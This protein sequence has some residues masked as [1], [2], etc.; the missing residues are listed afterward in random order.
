[1]ERFDKAEGILSLFGFAGILLFLFL[2]TITNVFHFTYG[3]DA[4]VASN[5][6][7]GELIWESGQILPDSWYVSTETQILCTPNLEALF[8]GMTRNLALSMGLACSVMTLLVLAAVLY[9][10][11]AIG[12]QRQET[13]LFGFLCLMLP[14]GER[15]LEVL[16]LYAAYYATHVA[17]WFWTL[18]VYLKAVRDENLS[19]WKLATAMCLSPLLG[20]QGARG[21]LVIY[22]PLFGVEAIR[23][24]YG[25]YCRKKITRVDFWIGLWVFG[26]LA[27]GFLGML[28]PISVG[29]EFSRNIRKSFWKLWTEVLPD[30]GKAIGFAE[31]RLASNICFAALVA[32]ALWMLADILLRMCQKKSLD[33]AEWGFLAVFAAPVVSAFMLALTTVDSTERYYFQFV[34]VMAY[35]ALLFLRKLR[36]GGKG[37]LA[38]GL[39]LGVFLLIVLLSAAHVREIYLPVLRAEEPQ[40]SELYEIVRRLEEEGVEMAVTTFD[41]AN[42]ATVLSN[43]KVRGVPVDSL[44]KMGVC[45]WLSSRDWYVPNVPYEAR[46]AYIVPE[47]RAEE[48]Q[49]FFTRHES[50]MRFQGQIGSFLLYVSDYN[51][52]NLGLDG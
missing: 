16:Y 29:R 39:R 11:K 23:L 38:Q 44:E 27:L 21:I 45:K 31:G 40:R 4:D 46:T 32:I 17:V 24:L 42:V 6:V 12:L 35:G 49:A 5:T 2:I 1:M 50:E 48:F 41:N 3:L 51:F 7:L 47:S 25:R 15:V 13:L 9:L 20:V 37:R 18:A 10:G 14:D 8:Y 22:G 34:Y 28:F 43:G 36:G 33:A 19:P 30:V 52:S 26:L